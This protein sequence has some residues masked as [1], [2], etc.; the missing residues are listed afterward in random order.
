[1]EWGDFHQA[2]FYLLNHFFS[3]VVTLQLVTFRPPSEANKDKLSPGLLYARA[4]NAT[5]SV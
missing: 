5:P 3:P 1:M 2:L 4:F